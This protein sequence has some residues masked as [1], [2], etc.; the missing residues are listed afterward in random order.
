MTAR[1][2]H[3]LAIIGGGP[4]GLSAAI[5]A[6]EC[7]LDVCLIDEQPRLG[8]QIYR[9]PPAGFRVDSWLAGR[10]YR[11]GK[12]LLERAAHLASLHYLA[13]ATVW[14]LFAPQPGELGET[15]HHVLVEQAGKI[16]RLRARHVL[17]A[18]GC[19]EMP[20]PFPGW[21][22]PGVMSAGGVQTLLK[23]Q[24]I[25]AGG[26]VVL[27]GS[28]P[29]LLVAADQLLEAGVSVAA[30][31]FTQSMR[32]M[33][34][35]LAS[36]APLLGAFPQLL[37]AAHCLRSI[38]RAKVPVM[39]GQVVAE[40][41]GS[42]A[43][44]AVRICAGDL[45]G[46]AQTIACD[47]VGI[48]YGFLASS[49]LARQAGAQSAWQRGSGWVLAVDELMRTSVPNLSAAGELIAV[50]GAEAAALSGEIAAL[51]IASDAGR[52]AAH[53]AAARARRLHRRLGR[54][55]RF[56][57]VLAELSAPPPRLLGLLATPATLLCR[58]EEVTVGALRD[59][60]RA[61]P[62][63]ASASTAKLL[64]RVG[65]GMC[66]GR[67]CELAVRRLIG[68]YRGRD[69]QEIDGYVARPPVKPIPL[70]T[71]AAQASG[72]PLDPRSPVA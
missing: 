70:A 50:A 2:E 17:L 22:L 32:A 35:A 46:E 7:G 47:T 64:T 63:V 37:H 41:I 59:A 5:A 29:L 40:A 8:G 3:E 62:T 60:L 53:E 42:D 55:R 36:P 10:L 18:S 16:D 61:E 24:R 11:R 45:R 54:L 43:V 52:L 38:R 49:E 34:R 9:Q 33:A 56:A 71:L 13:G 28:H 15:C 30:V 6:S 57:A 14:G 39:F 27:A 25:A 4:A 44:E 23:S 19:Y 48:C 72:T 65:M 21:H 68:E 51:G 31:V 12:A 1:N 58:C 26:N 67:M 20:V 69:E 66:Q